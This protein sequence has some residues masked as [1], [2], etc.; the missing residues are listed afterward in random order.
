M[1]QKLGSF[2]AL[3][4]IAHELAKFQA[5]F[6]CNRRTQ[7]LHFDQA[8]ANKNNLRNFGNAASVAGRGD[9]FTYCSLAAYLSL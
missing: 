7:I 5:L 3:D 4:R 8:L 1:R 2:D 9:Q 6:F